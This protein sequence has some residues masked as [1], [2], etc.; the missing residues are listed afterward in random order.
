MKTILIGDNSKDL[1]GCHNDVILLYNFFYELNI[2]LFFFNNI[3]FEKI[4][5][6]IKNKT[7]IIFYFSGHSL[8]NGKILINNKY[9]SSIYILNYLNN[10][11]KNINVIFIIDSC[12]SE[13]FICYK[14]FKYIINVKYLLSCNKYQT[15]KEITVD[16]NV[17][18]YKYFK[19]INPSKQLVHSIFSFYLCKLLY[20][21]KLNIKKIIKH[22]YWEIINEKYQQEFI[23]YEKK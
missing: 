18:N 19:I 1:Y 7:I 6:Y 22:P 23:Y 20:K 15:S 4:N 14:N 9:Y 12:Y 11:K 10:L 5:K 8:K 3:N 13:Q 16:Y 17:N 2:P 21:Y